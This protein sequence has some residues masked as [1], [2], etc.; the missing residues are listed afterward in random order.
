MMSREG[1]SS[2]GH[3]LSHLLRLAEDGDSSGS[4]STS[5]SHISHIPLSTDPIMIPNGEMSTSGRAF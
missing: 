3:S 4:F 5:R 2:F 1:Q